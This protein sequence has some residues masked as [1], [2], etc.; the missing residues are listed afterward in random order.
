LVNHRFDR[1][2]VPGCLGCHGG[3]ASHRPATRNRY[4]LPARGGI[5]C[6]ACPGPGRQHVALHQSGRPAGA[7][8]EDDPIVN[9]ARLS[10]RRAN[11]VC[12]QC[13]LQGD[14]VIYRDGADEFSFRPG[15]R[16]SDHRFDFLLQ[17]DAP[18]AFGVASHGA[19]LLRS[20]C[21]TPAG[22]PLTC[23]QCHDAHRPTVDFERDS[24]VATCLQCH[25]PAHCRRERPGDAVA[26]ASGCVRCH[27]PQRPTREGQHLVFTDHWIRVP[28]SAPF[29]EAPPRL[30]ANADVTLQIPWPDDDPGQVHLGMACIRLHNTMGPQFPSVDRGIEILSQALAADPDNLAARYWLGTG[31]LAR[32]E[33]AG[34]VRELTR[35]LQARPEWHEARFR[36]AVAYHQ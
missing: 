36:L 4:E 8:A 30:A 26:D 34:A 24:Y 2:I 28:P 23:Q 20:R 15:E 27:M 18:E 1:P 11:D 17:T 29:D 32:H 6:E 25:Q 31:Y 9:P 3:F 14:V 5:G 10:P 22:D 12:L 7:T 33:G 19:R 16:L 35:V 13:H 21:R